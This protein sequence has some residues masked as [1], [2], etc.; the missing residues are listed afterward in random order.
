[1]IIIGIIFILILILIFITA[2]AAVVDV[3]M[4]FNINHRIVVIPTK[5]RGVM[6]TGTSMM[7]NIVRTEHIVCIGIHIS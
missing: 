3:D 4:V 5:I 1:M 7:M 2:A 6:A